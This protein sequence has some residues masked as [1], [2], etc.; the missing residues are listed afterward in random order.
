MEC[1]T[2]PDW[3]IEHRG[4][5]YPVSLVRA[6]E[7]KT[8]TKT[9]SI[10]FKSET[11]TAKHKPERGLREGDAKSQALLNGRSVLAMNKLSELS[12]IKVL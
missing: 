3:D 10:R 7:D 9:E 6:I 2:E 12:N 11:Q 5:R 1:E 8:Y 4:F